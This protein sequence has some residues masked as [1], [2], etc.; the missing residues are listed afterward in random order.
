MLKY[1]HQG[2]EFLCKISPVTKAGASF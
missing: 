1:G 2:N